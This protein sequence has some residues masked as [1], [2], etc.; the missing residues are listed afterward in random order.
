MSLAFM[1]SRLSLLFRLD[2]RG[3]MLSTNEPDPPPAP[4]FAMGRTTEGAVW[5]FRHDLPDDLVAAL[6]R[7]C[8]AEPP[9]ESADRLE[10]PPRYRAAIRSLL[11]MS[12][13]EYRGPA[14]AFPEQSVELPGAIALGIKNAGM[15]APHFNWPGLVEALR[16]GEPVAA[17]VVDGVAVTAC[18]CS[19]LGDTAAEAGIET[20]VAYR[21]R[22]YA[23]AAAACWARAVRATGRQPLYSTSWENS[24]SRGV[25]RRLG[26]RMYGE[27][28]SVE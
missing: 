17:M 8:I 18:W 15:L 11:G 20:A 7:L 4:R 23:A 12:A 13:T 9:V 24:G 16:A 21:G 19:R 6:E 5:A 26:L 14:F 25:A 22:G 10:D 28:W 1:Q 3:R 2:A 27:D